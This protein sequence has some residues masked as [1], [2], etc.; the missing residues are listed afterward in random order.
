MRPIVIAGPNLSLD[1]TDEVDSIQPGHVHRARQYDVRGGGKGV[2]VARALGCIGV[3]SRVVGLACGHTGAAII[4][5]LRD[6]G[7]ALTAVSG[8]GESRSCLTVLAGSCV[9][10]FNE[11]GPSVDDATWRA[12]ERAVI[13]RLAPGAVFVIS[14]SL[15]PS[16]PEK[17]AANLVRAARERDCTVLCDTAGTQLERVLE[18]RPDVVTPNLAE[19]R[20]TLLG[21]EA[22][23]VESS[24]EALQEAARAAEAIARR[25]ARSVI[26]TAG[27]AGAAAVLHGVESWFEAHRVDVINPV[28]A[29]DCLVSG[30]AAGLARGDAPFDAVRLGMAMA[31]ASCETLPAGLL[32]PGRV[33]ELLGSSRGS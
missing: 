13:D 23:P 14:G 20:G 2:N 30:L 24:A 9:T 5:L 1:R 33:E 28:G 21:D 31:A 19:A 29:G 27:A 10:V 18:S 15:P 17:A 12:Y 4:A 6:E 11:P 25:G 26:V 22:E 32:R 16:A 3:D 8:G 7:I